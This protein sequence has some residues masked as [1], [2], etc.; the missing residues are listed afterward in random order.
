MIN[1]EN[2]SDKLVA[3]M[4]IFYP[5]HNTLENIKLFIHDIEKLIVWDNTP[6]EEKE[7][8]KID[9]DEYSNKIIY[10]TTGKNEGTAYAYNRAAEW[11]FLNKYNY[12]ILMDQDGK[13][14]NFKEYKE[15]VFTYFKSKSNVIFTPQIN[16]FERKE[17][18]NKIEK[19][20]NCISS[21]M[22]I[23][24]EIYQRIGKFE[25]KLFVDCVDMDYCLRARILKIEI[26]RIKNNSLLIQQ[27][28]Q[29]THSKHLDFYTRNDSPARTYNIAKNHIMLIKK[30]WKYLKRHEIKEWIWAYIIARFIKI[31]LIENN[32]MKKCHSIIKASFDGLFSRIY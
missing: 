20:D 31:I 23:S 8:Y 4:P 9:L 15:D 21:G 17:R 19:I 14:E 2:D 11:A 27:F 25:E 5:N 16:Q 10:L 24:K 7:K 30:Y 22:I 13:W 12:L 3:V 6:N 32:K 29:T 28:G 18:N 1:K 26:L